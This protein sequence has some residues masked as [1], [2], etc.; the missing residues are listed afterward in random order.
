MKKIAILS[1]VFLFSVA[2][3]TPVSAEQD[4]E[5]INNNEI[6][7]ENIELTPQE[8]ISHETIK[9]EYTLNGQNVSII[10]EDIPTIRPYSSITEN[11]PIGTY[12]KRVT[13]NSVSAK[14][15][16]TFN[17]TIYPGKAS[18]NSVSDGLYHSPV[19]TFIRDRYN[20]SRKDA[21]IGTGFATARY[22]VDYTTYVG[23]TFLAYLMISVDTTG[24]VIF[25]IKAI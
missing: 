22:E 16:A 18:V 1:L 7:M 9:K 14:M 2:F 5:N 12:T 21:P 23:G 6:I 19:G 17:F 8:V 3:I 15:T 10:I 24:K 13:M 20:I 4:N 11:W 25:T